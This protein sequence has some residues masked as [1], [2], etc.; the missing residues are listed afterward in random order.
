LSENGLKITAGSKAY[1]WKEKAY[2]DST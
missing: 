1:V 2:R